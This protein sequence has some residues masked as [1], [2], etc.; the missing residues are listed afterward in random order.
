M[1]DGFVAPNYQPI[2]K[3]VMKKVLFIA[4]FALIGSASFYSCKSSGGGGCD[5]FGGS[6]TMI[7][8][9]NVGKSI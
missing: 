9:K 2:N 5:A 4:F 8:H 1:A 3:I 7:I 6:H